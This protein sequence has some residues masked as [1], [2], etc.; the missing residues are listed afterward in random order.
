[1]RKDSRDLERAHDTETR[2]VSWRERRDVT[3][4]VDDTPARRLQKFGQQIEAG[5]LAGA[6]RSDQR[7]NSAARDAQANAV[8]RHK[9]GKFLGEVLGLE[10]DLGTHR[11]NASRVLH[12]P[13]VW[14]DRPAQSLEQPCSSLR[15][16]WSVRFERPGSLQGLPRP[17]TT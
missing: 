6:V 2:H 16:R 5:G 1:M 11:R 9:T 14:S 7:V 8:H 12:S 15:A 13:Y 10:D 3:P 4:F 17:A